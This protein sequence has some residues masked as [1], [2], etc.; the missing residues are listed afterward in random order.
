M[1]LKI[2]FKT[3]GKTVEWDD[4]YESIL[5]L[6]EENGIDLESECRMGVCGTCK[7]K[8]LSGKVEM[9][10]EDGLDESDRD[11][12]MILPCVSIPKTDVIIDA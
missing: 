5:E 1:S 4:N 2:E 6:G 10:Q 12:N 9:E 3:S 7:L 11:E 8:L